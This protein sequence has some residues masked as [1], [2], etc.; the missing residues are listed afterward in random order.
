MDVRRHLAR[1]RETIRE[2]LRPVPHVVLSEG[3]GNSAHDAALG[4]G[5]LI[6]AR[7]RRTSI[8]SWLEDA[9]RLRPR[10][11]LAGHEIAGDVPSAGPASS[12]RPRTGVPAVPG[13]PAARIAAQ[14]AQLAPT[15]GASQLVA[16]SSP[17]SSPATP[18]DIRVDFTG[19][20]SAETLAAI[21]S[22]DTTQRRL[23]FLRYLVR[24]GVYNEGFSERVLPEQYWRSRGVQGTAQPNQEQ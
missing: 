5:P 11:A 7:P 10:R 8:A 18:P 23:I 17:T 1:L 22:L 19:S 21:E 9:R 13:N 3:Q 4:D 6:P 24:Q 14:G 15:D 12:H 20:L 2:A 16:S